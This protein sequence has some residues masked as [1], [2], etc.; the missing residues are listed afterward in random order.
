[1]DIKLLLLYGRTNHHLGLW[2]DLEK[3]SRVILR[4][5]ETRHISLP[6]R[7]CYAL[8]RRLGILPGKYVYHQYY[9][10]FKLIKNISHLIIIDGALNTIEISELEKCKA[11]NP[12]LKII[13]YMINSIEAQSPILIKVRPKLNMFKWDEIYTFDK[14]DAKKYGYKYIGFC[15]Y[16]KHHINVEPK[17]LNDAYFVGG[18]KG[19]R[20]ETIYDVCKYLVSKG[21][22]CHFDLMPF[23]DFPPVKLKGVYFYQGWKPYEE[24]LERVENSNCIIEICQKGQSGAT[25][26]YFEAVS[27]NKKLLTNNKNIVHFPFYNPK[28]MKIFSS[29]NDIDVDWVKAKEHIDYNY[30]GE[31]SP[32][33]FIDQLLNEN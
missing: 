26:R 8:C 7:L 25:L 24:I 19:G 4:S 32:V 15:Y 5:T 18:L 30:H 10:L 28:W 14:N 12:N 13:L 33:H 29:V 9:D 31:F 3:D 20:D 23:G 16:S 1:M 6:R 22:H 2:S 27:M 21:A 11:M 17:I